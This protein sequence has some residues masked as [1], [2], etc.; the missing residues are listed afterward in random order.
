MRL[1]CSPKWANARTVWKTP[2]EERHKRFQNL[3]VRPSAWVFIGQEGEAV[4]SPISEM[5]TW[6]AIVVIE[7]RLEL[8]SGTPKLG[9]KGMWTQRLTCP[10]PTFS[11]FRFPFWCIFSRRP[12]RSTSCFVISSSFGQVR[13]EKPR[14]MSLWF[15]SEVRCLR[16]PERD[17]GTARCRA[18]GEYMGAGR[19]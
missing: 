19:A 6:P 1:L 8:S 18:V 2:G 17:L 11:P 4:G 9:N 16:R 13:R 7:F 10:K 5:V 15:V 12:K 3:S 14:L